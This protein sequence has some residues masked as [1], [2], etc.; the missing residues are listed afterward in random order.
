MYK[1]HSSEEEGNLKL[2]SDGG[3]SGSKKFKQGYVGACG[4]K[5]SAFG[6]NMQSEVTQSV[7]VGAF[8]FSRLEI[9]SNFIYFRR[10]FCKCSFNEI[11]KDNSGI[12][13]SVQHVTGSFRELVT[14][15]NITPLLSCKQQFVIH[16][17]LHRCSK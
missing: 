16:A 4:L 5:K 13:S 14:Y 12:N 6:G 7:F 8:G 17:Y 15:K 9:F 1:R 11:C 3:L 2:N 10:K